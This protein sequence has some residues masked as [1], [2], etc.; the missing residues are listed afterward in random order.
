MSYFA[1]R[2]TLRTEG[3]HTIEVGM[4]EIVVREDESFDRAFRRFVKKIE[5]SGIL[6][7]VKKHRYYEKPSDRKK[8]KR[9]ESIQR[10]KKVASQPR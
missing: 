3:T 4:S 1:V 7:D 6:A 10:Q 5:K 9:S 8:R 2:Q